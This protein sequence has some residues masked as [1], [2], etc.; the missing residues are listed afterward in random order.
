MA[1]QALN[2]LIQVIGKC[3]SWFTTLLDSVGAGPLYIAFI[4]IVFSIA[5]LLSRFGSIFSLGSD[6][7]AGAFSDLAKGKGKYASGKFTM[8][9]QKTGRFSPGVD[10]TTT[11]SDYH[12]K[13]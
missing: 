5:F 10:R 1:S 8:S 2:L 12:R 7:A 9:K 6:M 13:K 11:I 3:S 4:T